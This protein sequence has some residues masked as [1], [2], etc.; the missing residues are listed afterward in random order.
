MIL[1]I[2]FTLFFIFSL[3]IIIQ[4]GDDLYV[5]GYTT[6]FI[7]SIFAQIGYAYFPEFSILL[8][9]YFGADLFYEYW[10]FMFFSFVSS[11]LLY[12][13]I[14]PYKSRPPFYGIKES[15]YTYKQWMF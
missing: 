2:I 6:L 9:A 7:Y 12:L 10:G 1:L 13:L 3:R 14:K 15:N 5:I 11:F 4:K 8:G